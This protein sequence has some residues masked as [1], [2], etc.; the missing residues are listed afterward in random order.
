M[1]KSPFTRAIKTILEKKNESLIDEKIHSR[2]QFCI[3]F[4]LYADQE[5]QDRKN[6]QRKIN[7]SSSLPPPHAPFLAR[8][9]NHCT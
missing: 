1:K 8:S 6:G 2:E 9:S 4:F 5:Q 7:L 3:G